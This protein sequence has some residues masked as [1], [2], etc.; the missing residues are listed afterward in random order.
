MWMR[1]EREIKIRR[2]RDRQTD[3]LPETLPCVLSKRPCLVRHGRFDGTHGSVLK[4]IHGSVLNAHTALFSVQERNAHTQHDT[5]TATRNNTQHQ[6]HNTTRKH[7]AHTHTHTH[8]TLPLSLRRG[9]EKRETL[10]R[11]RETSGMRVVK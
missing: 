1:R 2:E 3:S 8:H 6:Q 10:R 4:V 5:T 7:I 9:R 11:E